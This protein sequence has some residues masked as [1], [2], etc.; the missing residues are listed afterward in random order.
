M[1]FSDFLGLVGDLAHFDL[2]LAVQLTGEK[3]E[4]LR[5]QL[6]RWSRDGRLVPLRRGMYALGDP[7]RRAPLDPAAL[8]GHLY[9]P[10]YLSG[11]WALGHYGLIPEQ[12]TMY[13]SVTTRA[14]R[15]FTNPFGV[16]DYRHVKPGFFFGYRAEAAAAGKRMVAAPEKALLDLWHLEPGPWTAER[17]DSMRF[18]NR[19]T[20]DTERL[21]SYAARF[22]R[23]RL[24]RA[25]EAWHEAVLDEEEG[26]VEL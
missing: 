16:F 18:Q 21:A 1:K 2:P 17:M 23:P 11:T 15:R 8:A 5:T 24:Y 12:V 20:V 14:P 22:D 9:A 19:A 6:H 4:T 3:R 7:H 26:A 13:T 25:V 10:S